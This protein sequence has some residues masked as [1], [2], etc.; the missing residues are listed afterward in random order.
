MAKFR[1]G[2]MARAILAGV[3]DIDVS[4]VGPARR[5]EVLDGTERFELV[6][7]DASEKQATTPLSE[8]LRGIRRRLQ[9]RADSR[10]AKNR[11]R[12]DRIEQ[13]RLWREVGIYE[14]ITHY[15]LP[16]VARAL[17]Y[18]AFAALDFYVFAQAW[19]VGADVVA[20]DPLWW[21]GGC[22]GLSVFVA[23]FFAAVQ[24][25]RAIA[26]RKQ[27]ELL[28]EIRDEADTA[29]AETAR[30]LVA[31]VADELMLVL[32]VGVF[33]VLV[34]L[35]LAVRMQSGSSE[36]PF[37]MQLM[38]SLVPVLP[39]VAEL[40]LYD[41]IDRKLKQPNWIDRRLEKRAAKVEDRIDSVR[42]QAE[43]ARRQV[44]NIFGVERSVLH[45]E[46][47]DIGIRPEGE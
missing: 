38:A 13:A 17:L 14:R 4:E 29:R 25:K 34:V 1:P 39:L 44:T 36:E 45:I 15:E 16:V 35:G 10:D 33:L 11:D 27:R 30:R 40:I 37:T 6:K 12:A 22:I 26:G 47:H 23:G 32:G 41:P 19:A 20:P 24:I 46:Q 31:L 18:V 2:R 8:R 3:G 7:I 21:I 9:G 5:I 43:I 42:E 28:D